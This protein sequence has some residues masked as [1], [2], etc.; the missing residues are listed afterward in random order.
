MSAMGGR[1]DG[2][3][4]DPQAGQRLDVEEP[5]VGQLLAAVRQ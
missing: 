1:E 5:P 2:F 3:V 4:L